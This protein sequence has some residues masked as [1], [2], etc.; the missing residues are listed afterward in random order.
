LVLVL[1][2]FLGLQAQTSSEV[3]NKD[4]QE[5]VRQLASNRKTIADAY[6]RWR[7]A[8]KAKD[9]DAVLA[10][11]TDDA[12]VLP[13]EHAAV[14]GKTAV[15]AFYAELFAQNQ[16]LKEEKF[17]NINSVQ[18]GDLLIDSTKFSG[19]LTK[20]GKE[21]AFKG[22]RLVVWKRDFQRPWKILRDT[23]NR[24]EP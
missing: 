3:K 11:Y 20:D 9:L 17:E 10:A 19:I 6:V 8:V 13:D 21:V 7:E 24:S 15:R 22:N 16:A 12:T 2:G 23:W 4:V 14:S 5:F 1:A 18:S